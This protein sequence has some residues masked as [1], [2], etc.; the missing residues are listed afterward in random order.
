MQSLGKHILV[1]FF[2]CDPDA[3]NDVPVIE[4]AM[5]KAAT[6]A[7]ATVINSDFHHFSPHGVS[8][9]V[10]IEESHLALHT[11][12][13]Y[14]YAAADLFTCG[15]EVDPWLAFDGMKEAL[16]S[17][18]YSV[19]ELHRG[20]LNLLKRIPFN[21]ENFRQ[22]VEQRLQHF[23]PKRNIWFTDKDENIALS[24]RAKG[25]LL[26]DKTSAYQRTRVYDSYGFGK[27]LT[28]DNMIMCTERDEAHYHE[29]ICHPAIFAHKNV[30]DVLIIGGGDGGTAQQVLKH[31]G[32]EKVILVEIDANVI[33]A[34]KLHFGS[35]SSVFRQPRLE[36]RI[37]DGI[38]YLKNSADAS[39][40]V[41]II[42][43]SDPVGPAKGLYSET[44]YRDCKRALKKNG[45]LVTQ[46][47][48]PVFNREVFVALNQCLT[49]IFP[50][51]QVHVLLFHI[52]TY[53]TGIWSFQIAAKSALDMLN[54]NKK[55]TDHF[56][57]KQQLKYYN[58]DI[59]ASAFVLPNYVRELLKD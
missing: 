55:E 52:F 32:V 24:I 1:E 59:H 11:W 38:E 15:E 54:I 13:E 31:A 28:I 58:S 45:I 44:F 30:K 18:N 57:Q 16:N 29:M 27:V 49:D 36:V 33:E 26:F 12:P 42:D 53:P 47:E 5:V 35:I 2:N 56:V 4:S 8:G 6:R 46:G 3:L 43:G 19:L 21:A 14:Q 48:S 20:P 50:K 10:I 25:E 51:E 9:V 22:I 39:F 34:S 7:G 23:P 17:Q 41:I 40:D 37:E